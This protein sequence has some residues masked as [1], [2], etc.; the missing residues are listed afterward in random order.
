MFVQYE[1]VSLEVDD[2]KNQSGGG[3]RNYQMSTTLHGHEPATMTKV[4]SETQINIIYT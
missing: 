2:L 4:Y 3:A 1:F